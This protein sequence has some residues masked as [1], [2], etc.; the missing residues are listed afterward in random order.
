ME[1]VGEFGGAFAF[2]PEARWLAARAAF[3]TATVLDE[4]TYATEERKIILHHVSHDIYCAL[5]NPD[6]VF[7]S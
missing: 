6:F 1:G 5:R 4:S 2:V 7:V 3:L